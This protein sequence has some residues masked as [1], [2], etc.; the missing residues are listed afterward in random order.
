MGAPQPT[1]APTL[2]RLGQ[3]PSHDTSTLGKSWGKKRVILAPALMDSAVAAIFLVAKIIRNALLG[4]LLNLVH[5]PET[6]RLNHLFIGDAVAHIDLGSR[7]QGAVQL[8]K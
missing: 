5:Q 7:N 2:S 8:V 4:R 3:T 6:A 1:G